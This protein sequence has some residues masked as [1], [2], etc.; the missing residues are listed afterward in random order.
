MDVDEYVA[1]CRE[2]AAWFR[3]SGIHS[4]NLITGEKLT[5]EDFAAEIESVADDCAGAVRLL[6]SRRR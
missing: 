5:P 6:E 3:T 2:R 1:R 4:E